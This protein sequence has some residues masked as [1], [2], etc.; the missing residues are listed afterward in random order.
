MLENLYKPFQKWADG[1]A[2]W[3]ISDTH[4]EDS[5]CKLM[6]ENWISPEEQVKILRRYLKKTDTFIHLGDVGNLEYIKQIPGYK[7]LI[8]G[9]HDTGITKYEE[10]FD[11][12]YKGPLL[13]SEK[14]LLS[15]EKILGPWFNVHGHEHNE[16]VSKHDKHLNLAA[17]VCDYKPI[18]LSK[19]IQ[20]GEASNI[21]GVHREAI[22]K[23]KKNPIK[24]KENG[25]VEVF[26][27]L[28]DTYPGNVT[29]EKRTE[30]T[31]LV[32]SREE[33]VKLDKNIMKL[34][35]WNDTL[36]NYIANDVVEDTCSKIASIL[37]LFDIQPE[38]FCTLNGEWQLEWEEKGKYLEFDIDFRN[39]VKFY[40]SWMID[41]KE[42]EIEV[43]K[44]IPV[45][46]NYQLLQKIVKEFA[47][48]N[49]EFVKKNIGEERD[50]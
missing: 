6:D 11:E 36:K 42:E 15:H 35:F 43:E 46:E 30:F 13:I 34:S 39:N 28:D 3:A 47:N 45:W 50:V 16:T 12:V 2:I 32:I 5:D 17:N 49:W 26:P 24:R 9:N 31:S 18:N 44:R 8:M 7:V 27:F 33:L 1:C 10:V 22:E 38:L 19:F 41:G 40:A 48:G 25:K 37:Y 23:A 21:K 14:I 20:R 4:F 29:P